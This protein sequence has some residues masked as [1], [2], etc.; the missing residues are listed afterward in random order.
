MKN[1]LIPGVGAFSMIAHTNAGFDTIISSPEELTSYIY[2]TYELFNFIFGLFNFMIIQ[3]KIV[4][5]CALR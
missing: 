1:T 2:F 5:L 3:Y 4:I